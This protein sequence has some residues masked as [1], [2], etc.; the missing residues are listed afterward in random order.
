MNKTEII[1][2]QLA[3][4][5]EKVPL[6]Y[7]K[8]AGI[9][10]ENNIREEE[11]LTEMLKFLFLIGN[12]KLRLSPSHIVDLAWHEFILFTRMYAKFCLKEYNRFIHHTP[13]EEKTTNLYR[14]TIQTYILS[15]GSP[16]THIWGN[17]ANEK[18]MITNCGSC[19]N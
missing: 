1:H 9:C 13:S 16:P 8:I 4:I 10:L 14:K 11:V 19:E 5:K 17:I 2:Q 3:Y 6:L 15:F 18:D 12:Y 7:K